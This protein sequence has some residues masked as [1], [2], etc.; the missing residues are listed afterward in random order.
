M[1]TAFQE[2]DDFCG[3]CGV[4][5]GDDTDELDGLR[6]YHFY[7]AG[8]SALNKE[9]RHL[10]ITLPIVVV[11]A[12]DAGD[13]FSVSGIGIYVKEAGRHDATI[14]RLSVPLQENRIS[15]EASN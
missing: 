9:A 8:I 10:L 4:T 7:R 3:A 1:S 2:N 13:T 12:V 11:D 5:L 14:E 15:E 6:W